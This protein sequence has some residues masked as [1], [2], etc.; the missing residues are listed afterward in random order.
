M[1]FTNRFAKPS[2]ACSCG[3]CLRE[4]CQCGCAAAPAIQS[5]CSCGTN[6]GCGDACACT[7][8]NEGAGPALAFREYGPV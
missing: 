1:K 6:C 2:K 7:P 5:S 4:Q 3:V 8:A